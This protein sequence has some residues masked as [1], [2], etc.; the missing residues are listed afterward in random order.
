[1]IKLNKFSLAL[2]K[3]HK[4][5]FLLIVLRQIKGFKN[6]RGKKEI[7]YV[8]EQA[9]HSKDPLWLIMLYSAETGFCGTIK[10]ISRTREIGFHAYVGCFFVTMISKNIDIR[11]RLIVE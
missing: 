6:I 4:T 9:C 3:P 10:Q 8:L 5:V 2:N 11:A 1:M 7:K